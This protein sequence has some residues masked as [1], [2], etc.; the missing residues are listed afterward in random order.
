MLFMS[1]Q[2][3]DCHGNRE[4]WN[5]IHEIDVFHMYMTP[6][7]T[8]LTNDKAKSFCLMNDINYARN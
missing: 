5:E 4:N 2:E 8:K 1:R 6:V 7:S 3:R